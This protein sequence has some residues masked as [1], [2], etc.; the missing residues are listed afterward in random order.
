MPSGVISM[1]F[2]TSQQRMM[3]SP[4]HAV[5]QVT[6]SRPDYTVGPGFSPD[7]LVQLAGLATGC[8]AGL[9]TADRELANTCIGL[10]LP[11]RLIFS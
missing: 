4:A 9:H 2:D 8:A 7:L 6:F 5:A 1:S 3:V 10:T 11:R